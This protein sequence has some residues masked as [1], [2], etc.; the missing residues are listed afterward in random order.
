MIRWL[1][2]LAERRPEVELRAGGTDL[3]E[4]IRRGV[5]SPDIDD[6]RD[7]P[8]LEEVVGGRIGARLTLA[9][10]A[11]HPD[12]VAGWPALALSTGALATPQIRAVGTLGGNLAQKVRCSWYRDPGFVCYQ[13]GG[14][15]C[16]ALAGDRSLLGVEDD[17]CISVHPSTVACALL[18]YASGVEVDGAVRTF[19]EW[20][21][22]PRG[23]ISHVI[24]P[25]AEAG[26]KG[27]YR[28]AIHRSRAEW[29]LVEIAGRR[30]GGRVWLAAGGIAH[31]PRRLTE[32]EEAFAAGE[33]EPWK[34]AGIQLRP[35]PQTAYKIPL[36]QQLTRVILE[37]L[38]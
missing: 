13:R 20:L 14:T 3:M 22:S 37:D 17:A 5:A 21:G 30:V 26:E 36:M 35:H 34:K 33:A 27:A 32:V 25:P 28:R 18:L 4:R 6:L 11:A 1:Q 38:A 10:L 2:S 12:I 19:P 24:L 16:P 8:G 31:H 15:S 7:V 29:P 9:K 23:T